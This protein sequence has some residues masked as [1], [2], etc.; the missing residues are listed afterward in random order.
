M[1]LHICKDND[2]L[3]THLNKLKHSLTEND[4]IL[5]IE[6]AVYQASRPFSTKARLFV[7]TEDLL[8]RGLDKKCSA[9]FTALNFDEFVTLTEQHEKIISW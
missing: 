5:L 8:A 1:T 7:L 3:E 2:F 4:A 6:S 9:D